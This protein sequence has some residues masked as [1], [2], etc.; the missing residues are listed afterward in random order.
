[1]H[2]FPEHIQCNI[3]TRSAN[4]ADRASEGFDV[5]YM[6]PASTSDAARTFSGARVF[7]LVGMIGFGVNSTGLT[8]LRFRRKSFRGFYAVGIMRFLRIYERGRATPIARDA[9]WPPAACA[10]PIA[11]VPI[12][13]R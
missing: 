2:G 4:F 7:Y 9:A 12:M 1:M 5:P 8:S 11:Y 3:R 10:S 6:I 13:S